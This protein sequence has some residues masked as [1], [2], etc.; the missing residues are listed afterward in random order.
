MKGKVA[1]VVT[2]E[3]ASCQVERKMGGS[4]HDGGWIVPVEKKMG[5]SG[6]VGA[7][8]VPSERKN[9]RSRSRWKSYRARL[10]GKWM[11]AVTQ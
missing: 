9:R 4:G 2:M 8:N 3:V 7:R 5:G 11:V 1:E 10:R 6:H